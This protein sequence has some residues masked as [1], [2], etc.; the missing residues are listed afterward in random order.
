MARAIDRVDRL[1]D[2]HRSR[3][4]VAR[5]RHGARLRRSLSVA[6]RSGFGKDRL[7]ESNN[8]NAQQMP[9]LLFFVRF[10]TH[11]RHDNQPRLGNGILQRGK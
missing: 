3:I 11:V 9:H 5:Q 10:V 4:V 7:R 1:L 6:H 8:G 2:T